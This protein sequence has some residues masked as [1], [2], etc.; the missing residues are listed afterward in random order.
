L[1]VLAISG[2]ALLLVEDPAV[3]RA[4]INEVSRRVL[5]EA[6]RLEVTGR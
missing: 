1:V 5:G 3:G 2:K 6:P 4:V